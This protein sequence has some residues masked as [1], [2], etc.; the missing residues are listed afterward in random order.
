MSVS[1]FSM[2]YKRKGEDKLYSAIA[3]MH[4]QHDNLAC[5]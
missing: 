3:E 5:L 1:P 2:Y 4:M